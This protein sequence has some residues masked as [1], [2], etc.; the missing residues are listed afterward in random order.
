MALPLVAL[1][2]HD[3]ELSIKL[4]PFNDCYITNDG[5]KVQSGDYVDIKLLVDYI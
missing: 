4:R 1:Q 5:S 2:Y 3:V